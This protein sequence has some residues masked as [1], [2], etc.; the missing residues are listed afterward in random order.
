MAVVGVGTGNVCEVLMWMVAELVVC[1]DCWAYSEW[2]RSGQC[3]WIVGLT[4]NGG[5]AGNVCG[6]RAELLRNAHRPI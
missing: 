4:V 3:V 5:G 2:W 1:V 6:V